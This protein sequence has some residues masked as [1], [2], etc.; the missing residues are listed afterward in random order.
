[1]K[2]QQTAR[3]QTRQRTTRLTIIVVGA[4]VAVFGIAYI[5][6]T[7]IGGDDAAPA[8]LPP[9]DSLPVSSDAVVDPATGE[10]VPAGC[11]P[12]EGTAD[13]TQSFDAAPPMCLDPAVQYSALVSTSL[14]DFTIE[15]DQADAPLTVNNFVFLARNKYFDETICHRIIP[16][17]VVQCGD[18]E[19]TGL[20][21]PG[22][23]FA[24]E[25]PD[26]GQYQLGSVAMA[27]SGT[28]TNGSQFFI[29]TG[30]QGVQLPPSYSL[31]GQVTTGFDETVVPIEAVGTAS[32]TPS[33]T[34]D[35][36]SVTIL[37]S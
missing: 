7:F 9:I 20:G 25:L 31:F 27:N 24:A 13:Q 2:A 33:E 37:V 34:V 29:V 3:A 28:D 15:L 18:P 17:F 6:N 5:A 23:Q 21:G 14:G 19:G 32:G 4:I 35:I 30:D 22:Y 12:A 8:T 26:A 11:P 36:N 10:V 16:G 1:M